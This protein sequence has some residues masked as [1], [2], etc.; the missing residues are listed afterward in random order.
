MR[1]LKVQSTVKA[2][3]TWGD[4]MTTAGV[5]ARR[6]DRWRWGSEARIAAAR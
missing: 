2:S 1:R 3:E 6:L 4:A 5:M